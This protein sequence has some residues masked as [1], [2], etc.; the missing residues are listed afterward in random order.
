M[1]SERRF[2]VIAKPN[3][4]KNGIKGFDEKRKAYI[5]CIKEPADKGKANAELVRFL[6]KEL[7][8]R[9]RILSGLRSREKFV[10]KLE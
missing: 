9:V 4:A 7:K 5:V 6:S 1:I 2:R 3:S 8:C 10:E